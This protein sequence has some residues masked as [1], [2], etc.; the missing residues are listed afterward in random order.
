[1]LASPP[2][3]EIKKKSLIQLCNSPLAA[4]KRVTQT[5]CDM[6]LTPLSPVD[7]ETLRDQWPFLNA[8]SVLPFL[9]DQLDT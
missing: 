8:P 7:Q 3:K 5:S 2:I 1:M 9:S 4:R 6:W